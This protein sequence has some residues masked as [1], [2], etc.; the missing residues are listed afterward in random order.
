[1]SSTK[2]LLKEN[3]CARRIAQQIDVLERRQLRPEFYFI[4]STIELL[5][6]T[7]VHGLAQRQARNRRASLTIHERCSGRSANE[8]ARLGN[9]DGLWLRLA[10]DCLAD[11]FRL[12]DCAWLANDLGILNDLLAVHNSRLGH[13]ALL[14]DD[15]RLHDDLGLVDQL[16]LANLFRLR[17]DVFVNHGALGVNDFLLADDAGRLLDFDELRAALLWWADSRALRH[18]AEVLVGVAFRFA[19]EG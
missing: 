12:H 9:L 14:V 7:G 2:T 5:R 1:M 11:F 19:L 17:H 3:F 16:R 4:K 10:H 15:A 18:R 6:R 8:F 13:D